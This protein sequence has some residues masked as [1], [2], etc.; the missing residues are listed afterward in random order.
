M[1]QPGG[2]AGYLSVSTACFCGAMGVSL[3]A[4]VSTAVV[5]VIVSL[6]L[7]EPIYA[8]YAQ[9]QQFTAQSKLLAG[10]IVNAALT[11]AVAYEAGSIIARAWVL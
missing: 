9:S 10:S 6:V 1:Q 4:P 11:A 7:H 3:W 2:I 8:R 5:L